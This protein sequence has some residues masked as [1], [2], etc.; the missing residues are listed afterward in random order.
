MQALSRPFFFD[1]T[2]PIDPG[3]VSFF[4][5]RIRVELPD[6]DDPVASQAH[7]DLVNLHLDEMHRS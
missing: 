6:L 2:N 3:R 5:G 4:R 7:L 1:R